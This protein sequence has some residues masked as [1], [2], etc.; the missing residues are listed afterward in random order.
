MFIF[1]LGEVSIASSSNYSTFV[2]TFDVSLNSGIVVVLKCIV[3]ITDLIS[4][5]SLS[6]S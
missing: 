3:L 4:L 2:C 6:G 1:L 5:G